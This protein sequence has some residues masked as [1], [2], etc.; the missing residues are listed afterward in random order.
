VSDDGVGM[1]RGTQDRMF[2]PFFSTKPPDRGTGLGL[3]TVYG[4]VR[5]SEGEVIVYSEPGEGTTVRVYLPA[6]DRMERI[7]V[8]PAKPRLQR[9][10]ESVLLVEDDGAVRNVAARVLRAAG[11]RVTEAENGV[12]ALSRFRTARGTVDL[13]LTDLVMPGISGHELAQQLEAEA[14]GMRFLFTSG[15][16]SDALVRRKMD[17]RPLHFVGKPFTAAELTRSVRKVLDGG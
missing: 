8:P 13:V 5:E 2:E 9:G 6:V 14:P 7:E 1:D 15:H 11:Y 12:E 17:E 4:I 16:T 3:S 10:T